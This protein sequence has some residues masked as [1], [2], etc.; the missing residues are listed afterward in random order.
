MNPRE[1]K[2]AIIIDHVNNVERFGLPTIDRQWILGG[3]DKHSKSSNGTS[4]KSVSVCPECFA[5]FYRKGETCPFCGAELGEEKII[6]TDESIKLKKIEA[7]KR[8]ALAKEIAENNAAK[9]VADKSPG[10]LTTYTEIKA[11]AKLHNFKPGWVYYY[12]KKR[13]LIH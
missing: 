1:G 13:G 5:T 3:R 9:A 2:R 10:E 7:N 6:E 11:Y 12:G 8:L 4:I